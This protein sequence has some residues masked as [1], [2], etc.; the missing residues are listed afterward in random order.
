MVGVIPP[1]KPTKGDVFLCSFSFWMWFGNGGIFWKFESSVM[2]RNV[3][4][5]FLK[6]GKGHCFWPGP[7]FHPWP[8][9]PVPWSIPS[10]PRGASFLPNSEDLACAQFL[11]PSIAAAI[12]VW[13]FRFEMS[14][15]AILAGN[16][17]R[18]GKS[19][20]SSLGCLLP[21]SILVSL[22]DLIREFWFYSNIWSSAVAAVLTTTWKFSGVGTDRLG[23]SHALATESATEKRNRGKQNC[24]Y[25]S[26]PD[27]PENT[28]KAGSL[29]PN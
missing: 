11:E 1:Y 8:V 9:S 19:V 20:D 13:I 21:W 17:C 23:S 14:Y 24:V 26:Y 18:Y 5:K 22:I 29:R 6:G 25:T 2:L 7:W 12:A 10:V 4:W 16:S 3:L 28:V 15:L 27:K